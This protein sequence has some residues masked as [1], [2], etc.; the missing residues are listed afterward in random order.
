MNRI[1]INKNKSAYEFKRI[2]NYRANELIKSGFI[3]IRIRYKSDK[4]TNRYK[5]A[6]IEYMARSVH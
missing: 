6:V 5:Y 3:L 1:I 2:V 4:K